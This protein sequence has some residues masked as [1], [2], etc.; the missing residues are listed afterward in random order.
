MKKK[1]PTPPWISEPVLKELI[2][3]FQE[4]E[5]EAKPSRIQNRRRK[6]D[7]LKNRKAD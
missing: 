1:Q 7:Y 2:E 5:T 6:P 3:T 4:F